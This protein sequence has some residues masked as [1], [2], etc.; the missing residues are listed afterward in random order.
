M[1]RAALIFLATTASAS[2]RA[3]PMQP[4]PWRWEHRLIGEVSDRDRATCEAL[5]SHARFQA[6]R[7]IVLNRCLTATQWR[8]K[9]KGESR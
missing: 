6:Y 7:T 4:G 8:I 1:K 9:A 5:A 3:W 2:D